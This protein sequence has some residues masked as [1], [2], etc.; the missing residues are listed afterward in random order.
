MSLDTYMPNASTS[1]NGVSKMA[2]QPVT[3]KEFNTVQ[4][5]TANERFEAELSE[6]LSVLTSNFNYYF[7]IGR[8]NPIH[9]GHI[10]MI[11]QM[12]DAA[13]AAQTAFKIIIF[14]G[15]GPQNAK[16]QKQAVLD[17]LNNP[18]PFLKKKEIIKD[19]LNIIYGET[20]VRTYIEI[21]EMG[22]VPKQLSEYFSLT[23]THSGIIRSFRAAGDKDGGTDVTKS[24]YVETFLLS[25]ANKTGITYEPNVISVE[26][27]HTGNNPASA[28]QV[29]LDAL[30]LRNED[31]KSRYLPQYRQLLISK[32]IVEN[33]LILDEK[34]LQIIGEIYDGIYD[35]IHARMTT[36]KIT[37][38]LIPVIQEIIQSYITNNGKDI[39]ILEIKAKAAPKVKVVASTKKAAEK[40]VLRE[41]TAVEMEVTPTKVAVALKGEARTKRPTDTSVAVEAT[42]A[43]KVTKRKKGGS[44][45]RKLTKRRKT[46]RKLTKR[47]LTKRKH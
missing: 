41:T 39:N 45:K 12:I 8:F 21:I 43:T 14:A 4:V 20:F 35:G 13:K 28:T 26:A 38:D 24:G 32:I 22:F 10:E 2:S 16:T 40:E 9:P 34:V 31:F 5:M 44:R 15:S 36:E 25:F 1:G 6:K 23:K 33:S 3:Y 17:I 30:R 46:R 27:V 37:S 47:K 42:K 7:T 11:C 29:R 19:I 18:I